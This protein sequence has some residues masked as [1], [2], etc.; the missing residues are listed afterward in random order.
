MKCLQWPQVSFLWLMQR[1]R[2]IFF[3]IN[4]R[5]FG[6]DWPK[7]PEKTK[8]KRKKKTTL[9]PDKTWHI[10]TLWGQ[11]SFLKVIPAP[12]W[13]FYG[14]QLP[15]WKQTKK[16]KKSLSLLILHYQMP[17]SKWLF[18]LRLIP[19]FPF[20]GREN[21]S[22][23]PLYYSISTSMDGQITKIIVIRLQTGRGG[24]TRWFFSSEDVI[25]AKGAEFGRAKSSEVV[26]Q[27]S[28]WCR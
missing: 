24:N 3:F 10:Y 23:S 22:G 12:T 27:C 16:N 19:G 1:I 2:A 13:P 26:I 5:T 21:R 11:V 28:N 14:L 15:L 25:L 17:S 6:S 9:V 20:K 4:E 18:T 8:K 7:T